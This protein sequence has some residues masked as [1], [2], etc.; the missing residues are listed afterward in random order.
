MRGCED[1]MEI[2]SWKA[3]NWTMQ[4][5]GIAD[6]YQLIHQQPHKPDKLTP[7]ETVAYFDIYRFYFF[8]LCDWAKQYWDTR[9]IATNDKT[10]ETA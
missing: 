4:E 10:G 7:A 8:L 3:A 1:N 9:D 5:L 6:K 2:I